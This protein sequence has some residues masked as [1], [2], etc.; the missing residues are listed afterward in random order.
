MNLSLVKDENA[1]ERKK[2]SKYGIFKR[3]RDSFRCLLQ[4]VYFSIPKENCWILGGF[5]C[6]CCLFL[7]TYFHGLCSSQKKCFNKI[8]FCPKRS[9]DWGFH[10]LMRII[11]SAFCL[12]S[13]HSYL[14]KTL[15][16]NCKLRNL[17]F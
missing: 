16:C 10:S 13:L 9:I 8:R 14:W 2:K 1:L 11:F 17:D 12:I 3:V 6:C 7:R 4:S 15:V 5:C